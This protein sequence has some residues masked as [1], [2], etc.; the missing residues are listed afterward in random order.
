MAL[1]VLE[2][3]PNF[4]YVVQRL[5]LK[6]KKIMWLMRPNYCIYRNAYYTEQDMTCISSNMQLTAPGT[7][8]MTG[9]VA[10]KPVEVDHS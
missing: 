3:L 1:H 6:V 4:K 10:A 7:I 8:G 2:I 9:V 5:V